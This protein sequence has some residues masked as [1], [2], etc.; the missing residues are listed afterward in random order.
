MLE[1]LISRCS[2]LLFWTLLPVQ[3]WP[4]SSPAGAVLY[5]DFGK[6]P[7]QQISHRPTLRFDGLRWTGPPALEFT[8]S[9]QFAEVQMS[10]SLDGIDAM[11]VGGW[12]YLR[13]R[14]EQ[15]LLCRGLPEIAPRGERMFRRNKN[16][17]NFVLGA[18]HR[19]F[20][21][22]TING[23]GEMPFPYVTVNQVP[24]N[25][26]IQLVV[27]KDSGGHHKF[28][29]NGT[30]V[31]STRDS[32]RSSA[33]WP[34]RDDGT[35]PPVRLQV[36]MGG[37]IGEAWVYPQEL[38]AEEIGRDFEIKRRR[39]HPA[40]PAVPVE[41][42]E[43]NLHPEAGLWRPISAEAWPEERQRILRGVM[44]VFGEFP[45]KAPSL[46]ARV[47]GE[48]DCGH[49]IRRKVSIQVQPGD[50]MPAYILIPKHRSGPVPAVIC[51]YGT[52]SGAGKERTVGLSGSKL[53]TAAVRN[54]SFALD[55]VEAG[56]VAF[57][58]DYL[59][60]GERISL[61]RAPYDSTEFYEK[62]PNWSIHGKDVWDNM[63]AI[64][65]LETLDFVDA[66]KIGMMGHSYGGH[67]TIFAAAL[68]PRI[69]VAVSNGPVSSFRHHGLHW[70]VEKG[71]R[72]SQSLP[73]MRPYVLDPTLPI[74]VTFYEFTAL[75]APRPLLVGQAAGERRP[76][77]EENY[78][79]VKHTYE[80]L[81]HPGSL[82][83]HWY[84]GD[85]DFPAAAR[86]AA[87]EWFQRWFSN[88]SQ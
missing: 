22:G 2:V 71:A 20:L 53:G 80:A 43:M 57:A 30:L 33:V 85:H 75:I 47:L 73:G 41:L 66:S 84:A 88:A 78:A 52:T 7:D 63:R 65:Y 54:D 45:D 77:E 32:S 21:L 83:Y 76:R 62:F 4:A 3:L 72:S 40:L 28:Y 39:Y 70:A 27:V 79:A 68:E 42:R 64:D 24:I 82:R 8:N 67:S 9:A 31:H 19:G 23:N 69:K 36:P 17:V 6:S 48:E 34:F 81:G 61:G 16:W 14:G 15:W 25:S 10:R 49:Y 51:F 18:D 37:L 86:R 1:R 50:R 11:T 35:G 56:M 59:R 38:T 58:A 5:V 29:Q 55:V 26:W 44:K 13:R 46:D 74:P 12:F 87:M 60:D